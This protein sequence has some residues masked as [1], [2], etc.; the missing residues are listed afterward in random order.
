M[1][2]EELETG[3][4]RIV[5]EALTNAVNH[6]NATRAVVELIEEQRRINVLVR[7][8]GAGFDPNSATRG[9]GLLGMH[10]RVELLG[11]ELQVESA[12]GHGTNIAVVLPARHRDE[13]PAEVPNTA[14]G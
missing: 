1:L 2:D 6:G 9:F 5:Q 10:E 12:P 7:D 8:N 14:N 13:D 4:Y 11:G 3:V